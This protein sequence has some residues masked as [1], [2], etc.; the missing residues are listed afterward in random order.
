LNIKSMIV[1]IRTTQAMFGEKVVAVA[2]KKEDIVVN[3]VLAIA[4]L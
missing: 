4:N 1:L 2:P 3:M